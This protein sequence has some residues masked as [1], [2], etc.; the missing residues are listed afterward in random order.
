MKQV[1]FALLIIILVTSCKKSSDSS[2]SCSLT[3]ANIIGNFRITGLVRRLNPL[4]ENI[5]LFSSYPACQKDDVIQFMANGTYKY[6]DAGTR[7]SPYDSQ[8]DPW[9]IIGANQMHFDGELFTVKS[10]DCNT[11]VIYK[12]DAPQI[13]TNPGAVTT[14]TL[15]K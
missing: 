5:D 13:N 6:I 4:S 8:P 10:F 11:L 9:S 3:E 12:I 1:F 7:C 2:L 15:S 14:L